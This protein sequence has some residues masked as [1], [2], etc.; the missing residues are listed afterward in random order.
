MEHVWKSGHISEFGTILKECIRS[1]INKHLLVF[2]GLWG[3]SKAL[4]GVVSTLRVVRSSESELPSCLWS[5]MVHA[6]KS[7]TSLAGT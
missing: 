1:G 7:K 4:W 6:R 2:E 3:A 5:E